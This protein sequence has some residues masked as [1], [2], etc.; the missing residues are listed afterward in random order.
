MPLSTLLWLTPDNFTCQRDKL[1][2]FGSK[3]L[4]ME[5]VNSLKQG[6]QGYNTVML[7]DDHPEN[8]V[9]SRKF[10]APNSTRT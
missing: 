4:I 1:Y 8:S 6:I 5:T 3:K 9:G 10:Q 2:P 7:L